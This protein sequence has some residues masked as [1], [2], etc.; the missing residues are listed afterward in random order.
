MTGML[1]PVDEK[2]AVM[3]RGDRD[4]K[5]Q[6][7]LSLNG[8]S[9]LSKGAFGFIYVLKCVTGIISQDILLQK[10]ERSV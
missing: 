9:N 4:V 7:S 2:K 1:L 5:F 8:R 6:K 10:K 3:L